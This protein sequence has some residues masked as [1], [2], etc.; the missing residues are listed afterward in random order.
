MDV[1]ITPYDKLDEDT[2][3][4]LEEQEVEVKT[5]IAT[6]YL[7]APQRESFQ[8]GR[9]FQKVK[10]EY[11][12]EVLARNSDVD[13]VEAKIGRES[14]KGLYTSAIIILNCVIFL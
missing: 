12:I 10:D 9:D 7:V 5:V 1:C 4:S 13:E 8:T 6:D 14:S 2:R 11:K 3:K